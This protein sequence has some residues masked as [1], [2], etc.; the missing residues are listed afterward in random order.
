[1]NIR[2]S[3]FFL[4]KWNTYTVVVLDTKKKNFKIRTTLAS[5]ETRI[6]ISFKIKI[7]LLEV[8][9]YLFYPLLV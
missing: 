3:F 6:S 1:M 4:A 8:G 2:I 7:A 5:I 9:I